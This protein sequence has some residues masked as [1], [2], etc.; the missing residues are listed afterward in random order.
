LPGHHSGHTVAQCYRTNRQ[1]Q[2][3]APQGRGNAARG[4]NQ[5]NNNNAPADANVAE[6]VP[7]TASS[8]MSSNSSTQCV[9]FN[10]DQDGHFLDALPTVQSSVNDLDSFL[11]EDPESFFIA[12]E[13]GLNWT[14]YE[15]KDDLQVPES[16]PSLLNQDLVPQTIATA[17]KINNQKGRFFFK[18]LLTLVQ[19]LKP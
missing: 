2:Q 17:R 16:P 15:P 12:S 10:L 1:N 5:R 18:T 4:N 8:F 11:H 9:N 14:H 6:Q 7:T 19:L 3:Q 13:K